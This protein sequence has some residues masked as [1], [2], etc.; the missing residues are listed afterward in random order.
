MPI[1]RKRD[2][3]A[4]ELAHRNPQ[5]VSY[6]E[7]QK[8]KQAAAEANQKILS[9]SPEAIQAARKIRLA[10][11]AA[12]KQSQAHKDYLA[13]EAYQRAQAAQAAFETRLESDKIKVNA[14][15]H[16]EASYSG[17]SGPYIGGE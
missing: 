4:Y 17:P 3:A 14:F 16:A 10:E 9:P 5:A 13:S 12:Y 7:F 15:L 2:A 1:F 6:E 8:L 11:A